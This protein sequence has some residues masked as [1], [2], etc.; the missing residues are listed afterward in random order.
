MVEKKDAY[1][2]YSSPVYKLSEDFE[3]A[4]FK[5]IKVKKTRRKVAVS[6]L[7][8]FVFGVL[9]FIAGSNLGIKNNSEKGFT[10]VSGNEKRDVMLTDDVVLATFDGRNSYIVE[11]IGMPKDDISI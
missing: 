3:D 6:T 11:N 1:G 5:K 4:V 7:G 9:V 8:A 10:G 2:N